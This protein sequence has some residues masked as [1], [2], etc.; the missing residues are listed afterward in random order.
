MER[1][2][3]VEEKEP[4]AERLQSPE[5]VTHGAGY[6]LEPVSVTPTYR[7]AAGGKA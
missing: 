5:Q 3:E 6:A 2:F 4:L 1:P 7:R